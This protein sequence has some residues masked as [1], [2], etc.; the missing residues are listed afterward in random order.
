[1][2]SLNECHRK[3][4]LGNKRLATFRLK[5]AQAGGHK[6]KAAALEHAQGLRSHDN[7]PQAEVIDGKPAD[8]ASHDTRGSYASGRMTLRLDRNEKYS[9][10]TVDKAPNRA[11]VQD[12]PK[13]VTARPDSPFKR[14]GKRS[15]EVVIKTTKKIS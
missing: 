12:A 3:V 5:A 10:P 1:M 15:V 8:I 13:T 2:T 4:M 11:Y 14:C 6:N 7:K 9:L